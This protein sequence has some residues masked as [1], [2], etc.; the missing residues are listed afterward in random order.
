VARFGEAD[1]EFQYNYTEEEGDTF[2]LLRTETNVRTP[3]VRDIVS[4]LASTGRDRF[5]RAELRPLLERATAQGQ[6][7]TRQDVMRIFDYYRA[8]LVEDGV[9]RVAGPE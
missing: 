9:L 8:R 4:V 5:T 2:V 7:H 3:Q 6:F 1:S